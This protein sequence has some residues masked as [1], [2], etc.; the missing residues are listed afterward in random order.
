VPFVSLSMCM[1]Q[2]ILDWCPPA[3]ISNSMPYTVGKSYS[4]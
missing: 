2:C 4:L 1:Q 3:T